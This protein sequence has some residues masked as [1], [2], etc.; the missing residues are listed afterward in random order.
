MSTPESTL[1]DGTATDPLP[2]L[3]NTL[4]A[5]L[6]YA[7]L[8]VRFVAFW[9]ATLLPLT[10]VPLLAMGVVT[11]NQ[12]GFAGLLGLNTVAFVVGHSYNRPE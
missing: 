3:Q 12:L 7:A 9:V 4:R 8:P 2:A 11:G 6:A 5:A 1:L 10:Y